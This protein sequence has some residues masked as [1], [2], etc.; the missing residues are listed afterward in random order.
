[1]ATCNL[2][3]PEDRDV[4]DERMA[5]HLRTAHPEVAA[6]GTD[7]HDGSSIVQDVALEP[8]TTDASPSSEWHD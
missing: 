8:T 6:D 2:C 3:P 5:D 7:E 4:P 1:M